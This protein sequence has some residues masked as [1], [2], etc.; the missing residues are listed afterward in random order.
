MTISRR[1]ILGAAAGGATLAASGLVWGQTGGDWAAT[2]EAAK[3]EGRLL[4]YSANVG[5][6]TQ[7]AVAKLFEQKYGIRVEILEG[8]ASEIR[9]RIRTEQASGRSIGDLSHNGSTTTALQAKAG[10]FQ[11]YGGIP[12]ASKIRAPFKADEFRVPIF[13]H[14]YTIL[15]NTTLVKHDDEPNSWKDLIDPK[16]KGK[17]LSDD[18]R[19]LGGGSVLFFVLEDAFGRGFHEKLAANMPVFSRDLRASELR[20]A[21]GEYAIWIPAQ[22]SSLQLLKGLPVKLLSPE[23]GYPF[24]GYELAVLK[25]APHPNAS[26]LFMEFYLSDEAQLVHARYGNIVVTN[27]ALA[28]VPPEVRAYAAGKL[29]GTTDASRQDDMLQIAKEIYK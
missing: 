9:E 3:K 27:D 22:V 14:A 23:E 1:S 8:R 13:A 20:V 28:A 7:G 4:V 10:T 25:G 15:V 12:S 16:W 17:I 6:P 21:R 26:R 18:M 29:L 2:V 24:I 5:N 19:A 11:P